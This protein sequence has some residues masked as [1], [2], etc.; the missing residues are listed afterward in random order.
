MKRFLNIDKKISFY[1][2]LLFGAVPLFVLL[3]IKRVFDLR[4]QQ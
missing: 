1:I 4:Q 2:A 3:A